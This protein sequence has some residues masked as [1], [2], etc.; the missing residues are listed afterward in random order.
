[1]GCAVIRA[2]AQGGDPCRG[3]AARPGYGPM[4]RPATRQTIAAQEGHGAMSGLV[5]A[6]YGRWRDLCPATEPE[7]VDPGQWGECH[8][9]LSRGWTGAVTCQ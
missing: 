3:T 7:W 6:R 5:L 8:G 2:L 1:M 4:N 9:W